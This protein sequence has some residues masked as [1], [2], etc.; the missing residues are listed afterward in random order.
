MFFES[1]SITKKTSPTMR[2]NAFL[3]EP[4]V[5]AENPEGSRISK[6]L[7]L[8]EFLIHLIVVRM[9]LNTQPSGPRRA[10]SNVLQFQ[11]L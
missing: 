8:F 4:Q 2:L 3:R 6:A 9:N 10:R 5:I 1:M 7:N 11:D